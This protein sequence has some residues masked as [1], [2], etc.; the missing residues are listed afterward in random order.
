MNKKGHARTRTT[1]HD[2]PETFRTEI[3]A[4][5]PAECAAGEVDPRTAAAPS[6]V[7]IPTDRSHANST[8]I[9][10]EKSHASSRAAT[11]TFSGARFH[12]QAQHTA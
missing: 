8:A 10:T 3:N 5:L 12:L 11:T 9:S 1:Q 4:T 6:P 2:T 7:A